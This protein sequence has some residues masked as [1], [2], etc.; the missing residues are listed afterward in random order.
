[1]PA[2]T[3]TV[4]SEALNL[5]SFP[6]K[7]TFS[8]KRASVVD[9]FVIVPDLKRTVQITD[10][11]F[12]VRLLANT[13]GSVYEV[14]FYSV[15]NELMRAF[16]IMPEGDAD[17]VD[18]DLLTA[19]PVSATGQGGATTFLG[20][21]DTPNAYSGQAGKVVTVKPNETGLEFGEG[22]SGEGGKSAYE[23]W[24]EYYTTEN[25]YLTNISI[26][27]L[28]QQS[29][30]S[31]LQQFFTQTNLNSEYVTWLQ[32]NPLTINQFINDNNLSVQY[33]NWLASNPNAAFSQFLSSL[34]LTSQFNIWLTENSVDLTQ[35]YAQQVN[36]LTVYQSYL[37][38]HPSVTIQQF[39]QQLGSQTEFNA[40]VAARLEFLTSDAFVNSLKGR[41]GKSPVLDPF[42]K[43]WISICARYVP[44]T[45]SG[46]TASENDLLINS[47]II[48]TEIFFE[49]R[50][51]HRVVDMPE[52]C[53]SV[54]MISSL[55]FE[56]RA[57]GAYKEPGTILNEPIELAT[58]P[59]GT[60]ILPLETQE[61]LY[62]PI[63]SVLSFEWSG[64]P[65]VE[66]I[67]TFTLAAKKKREVS[68]DM[69]IVK[70]SGAFTFEDSILGA[71]TSDDNL[72]VKLNISQFSTF[73]DDAVFGYLNNEEWYK[74]YS[75]TA[76][77]EDV[78][79]NTNGTVTIKNQSNQDR[80]LILIAGVGLVGTGLGTGGRFEDTAN[81]PNNVYI[82]SNRMFIE[83]S[84]NQDS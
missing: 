63:G 2:Y 7:A 69:A 77:G 61:R 68:S 25:M 42:E 9:S 76:A 12:N 66:S 31:N 48:P 29:N 83:L 56:R 18:L 82:E 73:T 59:D 37:I 41:D 57:A 8:L 6:S 55:G 32:S 80:T 54:L 38:N 70:L 58:T 10:T 47:I 19:W 43:F 51:V 53:P 78:V 64:T 72:P 23:Q 52:S 21:T 1:M 22:G 35:Y 33:E 75:M 17:F 50:E 60:L 46:A 71:F 79:F 39:L 30:I 28:Q 40:W 4:D 65:T 27:Q 3:L 13:P 15:S 62:V 11:Q 67:K 84:A 45:V 24:V 34:N 26:M 20:L 36:A 14:V 5:D 74:A 81:L 49:Q 44:D 16:F